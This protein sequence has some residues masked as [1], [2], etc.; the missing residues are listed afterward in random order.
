VGLAV[1]SEM[2][3]TSVHTKKHLEDLTK[4]PVLVRL[5]IQKSLGFDAITGELDL[6]KELDNTLKLIG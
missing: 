5:P 3:D 1:I 4:I 2:L 6:E